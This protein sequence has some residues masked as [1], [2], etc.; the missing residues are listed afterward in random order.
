MTPK[1]YKI[2][3]PEFRENMASFDYD[4]TLVNPK[5]GKTFPKNIDDWQWLYPNIPTK[6]KEYY[7]NN[8][9]IVIFSNQSKDWK[10]DQIKLVAKELN[11]PLYIVIAKEKADY[12]PN[13]LMFNKLVKDK[14]INKDE[15]F[16]VG[17]AL[18]RKTDFADSDKVFAENIGIKYISPE[19]FFHEKEH[20]VLPIIPIVKTPEMI[21]MMGYP[22]SGKSTIATEIFKKRNY[23]I[24]ESDIYKT[25][26]KMLKAALP[27][28]NDKKSIVF[29]ATNNSKKKREE[30]IVFAQKNNYSIRCIHVETSLDKSYK[31]NKNREDHKQIPKIAYSVYNK[32]Y[33]EPNENEGFILIKC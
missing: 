7:D 29:D 18:G 27:F 6:I 2:N 19:I 10:H 15:S 17:D 13:I 8:Y 4:W 14:K 1:I 5:D 3:N 31:R 11:L 22:A 33:N 25:I 23:E 32:Y 9:M 26:P 12:K 28:I 21:I 24:I 20:I 30:Y 16:Y